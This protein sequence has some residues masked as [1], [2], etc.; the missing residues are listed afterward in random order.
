MHFVYR[1]PG[2][3]V[4]DLL[5]VLRITKQSLGRVLK[6]LLDEGYIVQKAGNNDRRQRLLFAEQ[7]VQ[8]VLHRSRLLQHQEQLT[9]AVRELQLILRVF[10][11]LV[12]EFQLRR[13]ELRVGGV[14]L[15]RLAIDGGAAANNLLCQLQA[16]ILGIPV[17]RPVGLE[18]TILGIGHLAGVGVGMWQVGDISTRWQLDRVFEPSIGAD[19]R[20]YLY[21]G[22][23][24]AVAAAQSLPRR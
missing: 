23:R 6:Q 19:Q 17:E 13:R 8:R 5:D 18:R 3:K 21:G 15:A 24:D 12:V 22:W 16:D 1:Y 10:R 2:L 9:L 7:R 20:E 4:A 14:P 11:I